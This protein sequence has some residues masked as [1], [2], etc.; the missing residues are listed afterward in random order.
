ML[1]Q[2]FLAAVAFASLVQTF[3]Q[4]V[5]SNNNNGNPCQPNPCGQNSIC[6]L[7]NSFLISCSCNEGIIAIFCLVE[8]LSFTSFFVFRLPTNKW[9]MSE[10]QRNVHLESFRPFPKRWK[11]RSKNGVSYPR[12]RRCSCWKLQVGATVWV[13]NNRRLSCHVLVTP[14]T[15]TTTARTT[16]LN[17]QGNTR[18]HSESFCY[19]HV[20]ADLVFWIVR[21]SC[22]DCWAETSLRQHRFCLVRTS[23]QAV[24]QKNTYVV[25]SLKVQ[26]TARTPATPPARPS[27]SYE[28]PRR[29]RTQSWCLRRNSDCTRGTFS[30][31]LC[32][33]QTQFGSSLWEQPI[34]EAARVKKARDTRRPR[35][36]FPG[37]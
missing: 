15:A 19:M 23:F 33:H 13:T 14:Q 21:A 20:Q 9:W 27:T 32:L 24:A 4:E 25:F 18:C 26:T 5:G 8:S 29:T 16:T 35:Q 34:P 12:K 10:D 11:S 6:L 22:R 7:R 36:A 3:A 17:G 37:R 2:S 28:S 30:F 1:R 31:L